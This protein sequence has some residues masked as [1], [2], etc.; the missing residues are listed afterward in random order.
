MWRE[1]GF[2]EKT[3]VVDNS[4]RDGVQFYLHI[5]PYAELTREWNI[6]EQQYYEN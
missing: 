1:K 6:H 4:Y 5:L 2:D 3:R